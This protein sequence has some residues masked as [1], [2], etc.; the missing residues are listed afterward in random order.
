MADSPLSDTLDEFFNNNDDDDEDDDESS[1]SDEDDQSEE[2]SLPTAEIIS[3]NGLK[4]KITKRKLDSSSDNKERK[5]KKKKKSKNQ[6]SFKRRNIRTLLTSDKLQEDTLSALKAEQDR[7]K[8]LE[9]INYQP[10]PSFHTHLPPTFHQSSTIPKSQ[11]E[12]CIVLDD[13]EEIPLPPSLQPDL[14]SG[15]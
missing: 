10:L 15:R 6:P 8:R 5:K 11:D 4:M 9:E 12:E 14:N 7:L 3:N 13:E 1:S 2:I